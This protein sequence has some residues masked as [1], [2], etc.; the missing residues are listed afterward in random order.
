MQSLIKFQFIM[1]TLFFIIIGSIGYWYQ[2]GT[3]EK[4]RITIDD[5]QRVTTGLKSVYMIFTATESFEDTDSFYHTK[6]D[7]TD[8]FNPLKVGC[9]YEVNVYGIR[10]PFFSTFRNVVEVLKEDT[11][12]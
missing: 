12:P 6:Y 11:C 1:F 2:I 10:M 4:V 7:S 5:K 3:L 8:L 9:T